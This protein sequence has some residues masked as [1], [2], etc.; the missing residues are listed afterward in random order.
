M[1]KRI[2]ESGLSLISFKPIF[3][4]FVTC[5]NRRE[6]ATGKQERMQDIS[7]KVIYS[8]RKTLAI[9]ILPDAT[10]IVRVPYRTPEKTI[11]RL[12]S[13]KSSWI[14]KHTE[15]FR[16][17]I[18]KTPERLFAAG[19]KHL[20]RGAESV[21][22]VR[23][24]SKPYCRFSDH[25]IEIGTSN[26]GNPE[27]VRHILYQGYRNEACRI[28][29]EAL[30][31]ILH[32]KGSYGFRVSALR[33]RTMKS[34]WGSC[35]SKGVIALNTELVRLPEMYLEYVILHELCHL[36]HHNHGT[37]FYE[38]LSELFPGWRERRKE[39]RRYVLR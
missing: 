28:F 18:P 27:A 22:V 13:S 1:K 35:S 15:R 26:P 39:L 17:N 21:L 36:K 5:H 11:T 14:L 8:A 33:I 37:G 30:K 19:E 12:V 4:F 34:R 2:T 9:S 3:Y 31:R 23:E 29:P 7:Y 16:N 38:L 6:S 10:V 20:F 25:T 24:S 32:E